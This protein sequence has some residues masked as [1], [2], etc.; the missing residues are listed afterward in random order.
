MSAK[1]RV[2][3]PSAQ[4]E[5]FR[6]LHELVDGCTDPG[7]FIELFY[8]SQEPAL[9]EIMRAFVVLPDEAKSTLHAFLHLAEENPQSV[10]VTINTGGSVTLSSPDMTSLRSVADLSARAKSTPAVH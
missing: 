7:R 5:L 3:S 9:A 8:W 6:V 10:V 1:S 2:A 4:A